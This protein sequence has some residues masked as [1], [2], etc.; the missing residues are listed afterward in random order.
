M[1]LH[2]RWL[3]VAVPAALAALVFGGTAAS[4]APVA[5][6]PHVT[7]ASVTGARPQGVVH[8]IHRGLVKDCVQIQ[9]GD[10]IWQ[11]LDEGVGVPVMLSTKPASCWNLVNEFSTVYGYTV[12][13]GYEYQDIRGHCLFDDGGYITT[14]AGPC[15]LANSR[16][17]FYGIHYYTSGHYAPGW[18]VGD[19]NFGPGW[20]MAT[21]YVVTGGQDV[22]MVPCSWTE[23]FFWN[24]P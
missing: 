9:V 16:E 22:S 15:Q 7:A 14:A 10:T 20:C 18:T 5:A 8:I 6:A 24:F 2:S 13:T 4:P 17:E 23:S 3:A 11:I 21:D 19:L 1:R 12:Y